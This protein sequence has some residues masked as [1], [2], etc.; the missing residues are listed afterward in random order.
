MSYDPVPDGIRR[1]PWIARGLCGRYLRLA[2]DGSRRA[3][4]KFPEG[5][6]GT[7]AFSVSLGKVLAKIAASFQV[8]GEQAA[9]PGLQ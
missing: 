1:M 2:K 9:K 5:L 8:S 7:D 3:I 6:K 4:Y